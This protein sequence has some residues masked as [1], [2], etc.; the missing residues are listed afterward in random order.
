ML[1]SFIRFL[2]V[3]SAVLPQVFGAPS[4]SKA[5]CTHGAVA[6]EA[7]EC[8][9]IGIEM[10]KMGGNAADAQVATVFCVG[11]IAMYHS[12][13]GGGGF[14]LVHSPEGEF[15]FIYFREKAPAAAFKNMYKNNVN[16]SIY[17]GLAR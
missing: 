3:A 16:A 5:S 14:M 7:K 2:L 4:N 13:I 15:E 1:G 6:S 10:L 9:E 17:G 12:G 8:S 11:T